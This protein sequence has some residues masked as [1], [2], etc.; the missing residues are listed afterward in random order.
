MGKS[1][2]AAGFISRTL[3]RESHRALLALRGLRVR[4]TV[5]PGLGAAAFP[6]TWDLVGPREKQ[7]PP[8]LQPFALTLQLEKSEFLLE[9]TLVSENLAWVDCE[10]GFGH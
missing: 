4:H 3:R 9:P 5:P 7:L 10:R 8:V 2:Q 1:R 6:G